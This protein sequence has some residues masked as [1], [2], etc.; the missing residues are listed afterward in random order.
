M[1]ATAALSIGAATTEF[2]ASINSDWLLPMGAGGLGAKFAFGGLKSIMPILAVG[3]RT[4]GRLLT[5]EMRTGS[6]M[7]TM[8]GNISPRSLLLPQTHTRLIGTNTLGTTTMNGTVYLRPGLSRAEQISTLRHEGVHAFLSVS[9]NA[10][11]ASFRQRFGIEA[12]KRSAFL[13]A[14][15]ETLAEGIA[16]GSLRKGL[17]HA[18]N[19]AYTV[20]GGIIVTPWNAGAEAVGG[21][22][23]VGG[24]LWGSSKFGRWLEGGE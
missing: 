7:S 4:E 22:V 18:F 13:N 16:S 1:V 15:E 19:G 2:N 10:P 21:G 3:V 24:L 9:D 23:M 8:D 12:Y 6:L 17:N 11:F 5:A 20:R 14:A